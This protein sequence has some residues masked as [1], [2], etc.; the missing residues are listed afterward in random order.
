MIPV[1]LINQISQN[2]LVWEVERAVCGECGCDGVRISIKFLNTGNKIY[3]AT[4]DNHQNAI[5]F[6]CDLKRAGIIVI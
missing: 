6:V 2:G 4:L 1:E 5:N 3:V